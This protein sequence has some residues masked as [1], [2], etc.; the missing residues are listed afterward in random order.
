M[1]ARRCPGTRTIFITHQSP[2]I[3]SL[4]SMMPSTEETKVG[5]IRRTSFA[6]RNSV[7]EI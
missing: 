1:T 5:P 3:V 7:I 6:P 2:A 4:E